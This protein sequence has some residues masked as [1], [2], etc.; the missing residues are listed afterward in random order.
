MYVEHLI[1]FATERHIDACN[2]HIEMHA[3]A[4]YSSAQFAHYGAS[5]ASLQ[6]SEADGL[7]SAATGVR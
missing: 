4:Y 7:Y 2:C 5:Q 3:T 6:A 1:R